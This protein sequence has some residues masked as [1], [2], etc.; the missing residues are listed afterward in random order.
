MM[1]AVRFWM[2]LPWLQRRVLLRAV[3][4]LGLIDL[5]LRI[6]GYRRMMELV[7]ATTE[8]ASSSVPGHVRMY[9]AA[10]ELVG[11]RYLVPARCLHKSLVLHYWLRREGISSQMQIGVRKEDQ[12]LKAH[13]W[14]ELGGQVVNDDQDAVA[15]FR[16]LSA[17]NRGKISS[18][19]PIT[20]FQVSRRRFVE[21]EA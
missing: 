6:L 5:G 9:A 7:P 14:V 10:L 12:Q 17:A 21:T 19:P 18:V 8:Q 3:V 11:N 2:Q 4:W 15:A 1:G 20:D 13:A 16:T